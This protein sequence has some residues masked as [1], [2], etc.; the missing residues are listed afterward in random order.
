MNK[1]NGA[2]YAFYDLAVS[3]ISFDYFGFLVLAEFERQYQQKDV[4]HLIVVPADG[5]GFHPNLL[6]DLKQK[7]WRL[8]NIVIPGL[9]FIPTKT[10]LTI[11]ES[12]EHAQQF[13]ANANHRTFPEDYSP[14]NPSPRWHVS[15]AT[16]YN[17]LNRD[18]MVLQAT[19]QAKEYI[20]GG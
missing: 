2:L 6:Y 3:R 20:K 7:Q 12:R 1:R 18:F 16:L 8:R 4:L 5:D 15:W 17:A 10:Q 19:F 11:C 14:E 9:S 13:F